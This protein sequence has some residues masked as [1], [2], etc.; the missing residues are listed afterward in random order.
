MTASGTS[1]GYSRPP[2]AGATA[3]AGRERTWR[4]G[5]RRIDH[6]LM[7]TPAD[8]TAA[9]VADAQPGHAPHRHHCSSHALLTRGRDE[10]PAPTTTVAAPATDPASLP[11]ARSLL[12]VPCPAASRLKELRLGGHRR[13]AG[14]ESLLWRFP[15]R[16]RT[17]AAWPPR[18]LHRHCRSSRKCGCKLAH[19][20][21]ALQAY[22]LNLVS[23][24]DSNRDL[25]SNQQKKRKNVRRRRRKEFEKRTKKVVL[26]FRFLCPD[27]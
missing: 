12:S 13:P 7:G 18:R 6:L 22:C 15:L 26:T 23:C 1:G 16:R 11:A 9:A 2:C 21:V 24:P 19:T 8:T 3:S 20:I 5:G 17:A 14:T 4:A 25:K 27:G 10:T